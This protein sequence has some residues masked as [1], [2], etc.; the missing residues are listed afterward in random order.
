MNAGTTVLSENALACQQFLESFPKPI[1]DHLVGFA[2]VSKCA[3]WLWSAV[4]AATA[5]NKH[6]EIE[7]RC[8]QLLIRSL[9]LTKYTKRR[10]NGTDLRL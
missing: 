2:K 3:C 1:R 9:L 10:N 5:F 4:A 7:N 8:F 6:S